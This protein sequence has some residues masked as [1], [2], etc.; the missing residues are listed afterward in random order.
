MREKTVITNTDNAAFFC[1]IIFKLP[2]ETA[3]FLGY[4]IKGG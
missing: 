2:L 3:E 4:N 1:G